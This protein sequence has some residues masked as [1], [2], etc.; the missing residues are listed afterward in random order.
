MT[1]GAASVTGV[2][3]VANNATQQLTLGGRGE[4]SIR[5]ASRADRT[6]ERTRIQ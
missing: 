1:L 6:T 5:H 2:G 3:M 4:S